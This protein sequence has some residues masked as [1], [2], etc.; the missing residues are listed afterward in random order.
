MKKFVFILIFL[1]GCAAGRQTAGSSSEADVHAIAPAKVVRAAVP[2]PQIPCTRGDLVEP[3]QVHD[4]SGWGVL[5]FFLFFILA[6]WLLKLRRVDE[7]QL[8]KPKPHP[9]KKK[10]KKNLG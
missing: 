10:A 8:H 6:W 5:I 3:G 7:K 9:K 2:V 4:Q 1:C